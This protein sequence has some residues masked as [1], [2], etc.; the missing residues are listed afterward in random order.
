MFLVQVNGTLFSVVL[1][2]MSLSFVNRLSCALQSAGIVL[3]NFRRLTETTKA[4]ASYMA[5]SAF[6]DN[7]TPLQSVLARLIC[8]SV[9]SE[10]TIGVEYL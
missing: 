2:R 5:L 7:C 9:A 1:G 4:F 10:L 6:H 3:S 8:E